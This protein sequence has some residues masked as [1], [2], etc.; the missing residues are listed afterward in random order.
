MTGGQA[1]VL[2]GRRVR[3]LPGG[4]GWGAFP[5]AG[6]HER[7]VAAAPPAPPGAAGRLPGVAAI[8]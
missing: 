7:V 4:G 1:G 8:E 2:P 5:Q 6:V 3:G